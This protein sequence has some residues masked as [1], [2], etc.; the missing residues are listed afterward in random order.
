VLTSL[1]GAAFA[2]TSASSKP[3]ATIYLQLASRVAT[4]CCVQQEYPLIT[5]NFS[6]SVATHST[7]FVTVTV[8]VPVSSGCCIGAFAEQIQIDKGPLHQIGGGDTS[9]TVG[10]RVTLTAFERVDLSAGLHSVTL[11]VFN[12]GGSWAI[13]SGPLTA[14]LVEFS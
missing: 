1:V 13:D 10:I 8:F 2:S 14:L 4:S 9:R 7:I 12:G 5:A 11:E 3:P 6:S